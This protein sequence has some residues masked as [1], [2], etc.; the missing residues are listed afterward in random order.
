MRLGRPA[1]DPDARLWVLVVAL[2]LIVAY[3]VAFVVENDQKVNVHF[4]FF[5]AHTSVI[6]LILLSIA[7][8]LAA[9]MLLAQLT[10][11][12]RRNQPG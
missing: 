12:R 6:W 8:G 11:R 1:V 4:V 7:I 9:G 10:R 2:A 3:V 5:T